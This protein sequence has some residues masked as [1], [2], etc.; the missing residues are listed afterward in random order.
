ML[1]HQD[2]TWAG[3]YNRGSWLVSNTKRATIV[4]F[5]SATQHLDRA[6][7]PT[8][9]GNPAEKGCPCRRRFGLI[10]LPKSRAGGYRLDGRKADLAQLKALLATYLTTA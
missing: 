7:S 1:H 10:A 2:E 5:P 4:T 9:E 8:A 6:F 3:Q